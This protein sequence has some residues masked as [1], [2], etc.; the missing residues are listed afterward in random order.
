VQVDSFDPRYNYYAIICKE[1]LAYA[2]FGPRLNG[3]VAHGLIP[4]THAKIGRR[5]MVARVIRTQTRTPVEKENPR[6]GWPLELL[7]KIR[8]FRLTLP[9]E[10]SDLAVDM[11]G[12]DQY[13]YHD[14]QLTPPKRM[15]RERNAA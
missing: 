2:H 5:K 3:F 1:L 15:L 8:Q 6:S 7:Y 4:L 13:H 12:L 11:L 14:K 9:Q 10:A